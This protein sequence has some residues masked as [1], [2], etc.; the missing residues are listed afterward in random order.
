MTG[1]WEK[2]DRELRE[3]DEG[4]E[5]KKEN[6]QIYTHTHIHMY[7]LWPDTVDPNLWAKHQAG[8]I[9]ASFHTN[10]PS[11]SLGL[12]AELLG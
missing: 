1:W 11:L 8:L 6:T 5:K 7:T 2:G 4:K 9:C 10:T 12:P 3:E